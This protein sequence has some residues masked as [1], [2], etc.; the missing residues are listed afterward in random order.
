MLRYPP[1]EITP[2]EFEEY[3]AGLFGTLRP[4][5]GVPRVELHDRV[6]GTDGSYDFDATVRYQWA[7]ME[8]LVV[9][10]A[11]LHKNP[12]KREPVQALHSKAQ[13]VGA[14]KAVMVATAPYQRGALAFAKVHGIALVVLT[15]GRFTYEVRTRTR[16]APALSR[17]EAAGRFG[18]PTFVGH[19]YGAGDS[20]RSTTCTLVSPEHPEYIE[21]LLLGVPNDDVR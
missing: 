13:A 7:G 1:A 8:F 20:P 17:E 4:E 6:E 18:L 16:A 9:I 15:E 12:I 14:H 11:K 5:I 10:E 21:N 19:C 3:V 2:R